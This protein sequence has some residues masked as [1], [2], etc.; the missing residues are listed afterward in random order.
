MFKH[1]FNVFFFFTYSYVEDWSHFCCFSF[2]EELFPPIY[3]WPYEISRCR[4]H[5]TPG[6]H[7]LNKLAFT[8]YLRTLTH[9]LQLFFRSLC[10]PNS[11]KTGLFFFFINDQ[12]ISFQ[13]FLIPRIPLW[14]RLVLHFLKLEFPLSMDSL[15][16]VQLCS[17]H[18]LRPSP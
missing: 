9:K 6:D 3:S 10:L 2:G 8:L 4:P 16:Q 7:A 1:V 18:L 15:S 5:P 14:K 12:Q 17:N 13:S 11:Q